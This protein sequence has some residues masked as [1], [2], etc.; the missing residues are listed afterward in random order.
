LFLR[1]LDILTDEINENLHGIIDKCK[2]LGF[3]FKIENIFLDLF[4]GQIYADKII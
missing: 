1:S 3:S 2:G 4:F